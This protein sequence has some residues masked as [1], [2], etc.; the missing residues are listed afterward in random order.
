M[1]SVEIEWL[2]LPGLAMQKEREMPRVYVVPSNIGARGA[3]SFEV[4]WSESP[5]P[6]PQ[7]SRA[8]SLGLAP[9]AAS[10]R[11]TLVLFSQGASL[12]CPV[13]Q[14]HWG[15]CIQIMLLNG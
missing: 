10:M 7:P 11:P 8:P 5:L 13:D 3:L 15:G 9:S 6:H 2:S 12:T 14:G 1:I 4:G